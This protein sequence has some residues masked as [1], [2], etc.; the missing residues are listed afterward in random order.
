MGQLR[1]YPRTAVGLSTLLK[2]ST[3]LRGELRVMLVAL[4]PAWCPPSVISTARDLKGPAHHLDGELVLVFVHQFV[5][6]SG[7]LD[8]IAK[9]FF[10]TSRS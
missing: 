6:R 4:C 10:N 1:V 9:A 8:K 2:H 3:N 7:L 5:D